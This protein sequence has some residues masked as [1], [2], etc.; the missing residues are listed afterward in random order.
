M[1]IKIV[2]AIIYHCKLA[3]GT[4]LTGHIEYCKPDSSSTI[5]I[6]GVEYKFERIKY[7]AIY[8]GDG[9]LINIDGQFY[10]N[11]KT[12]TIKV[13]PYGD[14]YVREPD[15]EASDW[16][17]SRIGSAPSRRYKNEYIIL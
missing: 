9:N 16:F 15:D 2:D 7:Y 11:E 1:S 14:L 4:S 6:N 3:L 13:T 10:Y 12:Y 5:K 8:D 17:N